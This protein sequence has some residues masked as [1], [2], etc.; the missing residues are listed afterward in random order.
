MRVG[1]ALVLLLPLSCIAADDGELWEVTSQ[2]NIPGMPAGMAGMGQAPQRVCTGKDPKQDATKRPDMKDCKVTDFKQTGPRMTMTLNCPRG[3]AVIDQTFNAARTEYKGSMKMTGKDGEMVINTSGRK[4]GTCDTAQATRERDDKVA[5]MK[6]QGAAAT[7]AAN[8]QMA[9]AQK[10]TTATITKAC[11]EA[12]AAMNASKFP[13]CYNPRDPMTKS[14]MCTDPQVR[15]SFVPP[16][17]KT[18]CDAKKAE[19]CQKYQ[20]E[21][22]FTL[23]AQAEKEGADNGAALC[24]VQKPKVQATLCTGALKGESLEFLSRYCPAEI[25]QVGAKLC[26]KAV[27]TE[28]YHY[29]YRNCPADAKSL[30]AK[31]CAGRQ[32]TS[33]QDR[34]MR[35]M[36][37]TL[38]SLE[39]ESGGRVLQTGSPPTATE[40]VQQGVTKGIDKLKGLFGR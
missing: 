5:K 3:Q 6:A 9:E 14:A 10:Q 4:L 20:T 23:A 18:V 16:A 37:T 38:A 21:A 1:L 25:K 28:A 13:A 33:L 11:N 29:I 27:Q 30:F 35:N 40:Q 26:P 2:M 32:Y 36:C 12:T 22:G 17:G 31:N 15:N 8:Q 7:A 34:K 39:E 24:G 19:F